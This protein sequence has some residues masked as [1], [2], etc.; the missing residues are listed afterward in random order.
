MV[1]IGVGHPWQT[2]T[3]QTIICTK[4]FSS[5]K[6]LLGLGSGPFS[7]NRLPGVC[8][9]WGLAVKSPVLPGSASQAV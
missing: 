7:Q 6:G 4:G 9:L 2:D 3:P 5:G 1:E 8:I